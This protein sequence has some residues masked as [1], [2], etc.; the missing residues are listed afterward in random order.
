MPPSISDVVATPP[1]QDAGEAVRISATVIDNVA[2]ADVFLNITYPD[3]SHHNFSIMQNV[4]GNT[5]Y[6][7]KSYDQLGTYNFT[8]YAVDGAGNGNTSSSSFNIRD[9]TPPAVEVVY[10]NGGEN[11]SGNVTIKWNATDNYDPANSLKVT[12]KYSIDGGTSWHTIVANKGNTG[13]YEWNTSGLEDGHSYLLKISVK[14]SSN[15]QGTDMSNSAFTVDNTQ[16]SL[17]LQKPCH[18]H[19]YLLDREVMPILRTKAVIIGKITVTV[20]ATDKTSGVNRVEFFVDNVVKNVDTGA[21]YEWEWNEKSFT[22]HTLK[23]VA[24][25]NAGNSVYEELDVKVYNI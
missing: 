12:I 3:E 18:N 17:V 19:L 11:L 21:P 15:N 1:V 24:Y 4:T 6:C 5:Y 20:N 16:P 25:D 7:E 9:T 14:D 8:I 22:S 10:P 23:V 13:E 2:V